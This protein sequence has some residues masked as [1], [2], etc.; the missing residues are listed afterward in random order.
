MERVTETVLETGTGRLWV[1]LSCK[2]VGDALSV[3]IVGGEKPH[4]GAAAIAFLADGDVRVSVL[5]GPGHRESE[6][7]AECAEA[8]CRAAGRTVLVS[9]GIHIDRASQEEI[10]E[11]CENTRSLI[12]R[13]NA[14]GST[15]V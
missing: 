4:I 12:S 15:E 13:L 7:A 6:L 2:P 1:C 11:L 9:C 14:R 8:T 3:S 5:T 10:S